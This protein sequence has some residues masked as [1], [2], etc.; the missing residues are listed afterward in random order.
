MYNR[1]VDK[2]Y[3]SY[4]TCGMTVK[5]VTQNIERCRYLTSVFGAC[6]CVFW[7]YFLLVTQSMTPTMSLGKQHV[8]V[9]CTSNSSSGVTYSNAS[10]KAPPPP[11]PHCPP[12]KCPLPPPAP[13]AWT[14]RHRHPAGTWARVNS[15]GK[16][17]REGRRRE[18]GGHG[19]E[20]SFTKEYSIAVSLNGLRTASRLGLIKNWVFDKTHLILWTLGY[21]ATYYSSLATIS[22]GLY[23]DAHL[24]SGEV[25]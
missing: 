3:T 17:R 22:S 2:N 16:E 21:Q 20:G 15:R 13:H 8:S 14:F 12:W 5:Q 10:A 1:G 23:F 7:W 18:K 11:S 25:T 4:T 24:T 19:S 9:T 6:Y